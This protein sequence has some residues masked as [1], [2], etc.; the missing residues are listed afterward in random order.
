MA[1]S[2]DDHAKPATEKMSD[3]SR[4]N[5][6]KHRAQHMAPIAPGHIRTSSEAF[7]FHGDTR[8]TCGVP[9]PPFAALAR[10]QA[11]QPRLERISI[12]V[13]IITRFGLV[14]QFS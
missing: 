9:D 10:L 11:L 6:G 8:S 12:N 7:Q 5:A 4:T 3:E 14:Y 1:C 13:E 2:T